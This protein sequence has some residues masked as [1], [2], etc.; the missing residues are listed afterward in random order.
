M[1]THD[2]SKIYAKGT[3]HC[4]RAI[5]EFLPKTDRMP[6]RVRYVSKIGGPESVITVISF[7][8]W[9]FRNKGKV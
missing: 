4:G 7:R 8:S 3:I 5:V 1:K 2:W 9:C 6:D